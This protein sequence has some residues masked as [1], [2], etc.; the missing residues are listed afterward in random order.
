LSHVPGFSKRRTVVVLMML[1]I[2]A[3]HILRIG[4]YLQGE[5][6]ILYNFWGLLSTRLIISCMP[7]VQCQPLLSAR[8]Y[9]L[10]FSTFGLRKNM[11]DVSPFH[12]GGSYHFDPCRSAFIQPG[13]L[14]GKTPPKRL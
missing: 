4:S 9:F 5:L 6:L 3:A 14:A 1:L 2:A 12:L 7:S 13:R 10:G 8:K 11:D